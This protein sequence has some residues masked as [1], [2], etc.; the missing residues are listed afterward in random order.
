MKKALIFISG[1]ISGFIVIGFLG[2][3]YETNSKNEQANMTLFK[4]AGECI[5]TKP[6]KIFQVID[7]NHALAEELK[8]LGRYDIPTET[9]VLFYNETAN[10]FYDNQI[11]KIPKEY[12]A[13]QIGIYR[14]ETNI[15]THKTIPIVKILK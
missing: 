7:K 3:F 8:G 2:Y 6:F 4:Q 15:G 12:C 10:S 5:S 14:Y 9:I 1:L 11:I 13:K